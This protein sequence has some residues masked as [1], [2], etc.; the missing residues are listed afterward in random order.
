MRL[1]AGSAAYLFSAQ[2]VGWTLDWGRVCLGQSHVAFPQGGIYG[3]VVTKGGGGIPMKGRFQPPQITS[4]DKSG[5]AAAVSLLQSTRN[6][7]CCI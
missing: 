6:N 4:L 3:W 5:T 2:S 1:G 7:F